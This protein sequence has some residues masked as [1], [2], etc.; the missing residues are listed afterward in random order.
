MLQEFE[1]YID[2]IDFDN[3]EFTAVLFD[4]TDY[5]V[6]STE[7][8]TFKFGVFDKNEYHYIKEGL[9]FKWTITDDKNGFIINKTVFTKEALERAD[10]EARLFKS[11]EFS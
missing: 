3:K 7:Y 6:Y 8:A 5:D 11:I 10:N 2:E 1:C 4:L 9:I